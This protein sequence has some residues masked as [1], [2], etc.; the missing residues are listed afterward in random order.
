[1]RKETVGQN[2]SLGECPLEC[3]IRMLWKEKCK[4][5]VDDTHSSL[6]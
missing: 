5:V 1:M 2:T 4:G 3:T 6:S